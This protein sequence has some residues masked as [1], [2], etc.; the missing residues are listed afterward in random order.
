MNF[1]HNAL[2]KLAISLRPLW[3]FAWRM[4]LT[5]T[6]CRLV[7]VAWQWQRVIDA[8]LLGTVFIQG[9]RFDFV[10]LG[11]MLTIPVLCFPLLASNRFLVSSW[12]SLLRICLPLALLLVVFMECSTPSFVDQFDSRPNILFFE[13]LNSPREV[14]AT[15]WAAYKIP[16]LL[17]SVIVTMITWLNA[18]QIGKLVRPIQPTGV[19]PALMVTPLLLI[20]CFGFIRSTTDHRAVNPSTVALSNDPLVNELALSSMY[21]ALYALYETRHEA[22]GGFRYAEI[23]D[24]EVLAEVRASMMIDEREFTSDFLPTLHHQAS[25]DPAIKP[26]NLVIIVQESLGAEFVGALGGTGVTPNLDELSGEG[27]WFSNLYATGTR[28]ARGLEAIISGFTPTPARSVVKLGRSQRNFFTLAGLLRE[29]GYDTSFIYGG[30]SQFDNMR[31]FFMNNGFDRVIDKKDYE[32]P[33]FTGSWGVSDEDLFDRAHME[34]SASHKRP[35]F[36]LVFTSSNHSPFEY[37]DGRIEQYDHEKNTVNNAVKYADYAFGQF[38]RNAKQS[39]YWDDTVF[40]VVADHNSR[41]YGSEV[42]PVE[43]FHIPGLILGGSV[44]PAVFEPVASQIDLGPTLLSLISVESEH[45]MIGHDLTRPEMQEFAGRAIM[46]FN[47]TQAYMEGDQVAVLQKNQPV[48]QYL[49]TDG[50]LELAGR[51]DPQ[52]ATRALAHSAW[53]SMA[54]EKLLYRM[55]SSGG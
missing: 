35:F 3:S 52:L 23:D 50:H 27:I 46:Q 13:Y 45:P 41:V 26:M 19:I 36:S 16:I 21:T 31:R 15:L 55:P 12:R 7:F 51:V 49:L 25:P 37:P 33:V 48:R 6:I 20:I 2:N 53:S 38:I 43:R 28:S 8:D 32:N 4:L 9:L 17:A 1:D 11:L 34:F 29:S 18:G 5:L 30:E 14:G 47:G 44:S 40:M 54:Y 22:Q 24:Q 42:V 39:K 10:L